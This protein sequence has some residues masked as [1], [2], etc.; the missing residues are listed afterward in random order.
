M[1]PPVEFISKTGAEKRNIEYGPFQKWL[2]P[3]WVKA[4]VHLDSSTEPKEVGSAFGFLII[5]DRIRTTFHESMEPPSDET[6]ELAFTLFD[7]YGELK[8]EIVDHAVRKGSG[9]W[10]DELNTGNFVLIEKVTVNKKWRRRGIGTKLVLLLL[11]KAIALRSNVNFAFAS[12][13]LVDDWHS[14]DSQGEMTKEETRALTRSRICAV[15]SLFR[16][17]HFRRV[18]ITEWFAL[19]KDEKHLSRQL[20]SHEDAGPV[21]DDSSDAD[22]D[23]KMLFTFSSELD[24]SN[25]KISH[26]VLS[27]SDLESDPQTYLKAH[28]TGK[29]PVR[30]KNMSDLA[31]I[32]GCTYPLHYAIRVLAD[33]DAVKFL[34]SHASKD[35]PGGLD[36][37]DGRGDTVLHIA[38]T[39]SKIGCL[40]WILDFTDSERL[41]GM[42]NREG[43]TAKE[44]LEARLE[45][46]RIS[47]PYGWQRR[48]YKADKFDGFDDNSV[49]CLLKFAGIDTPTTEQQQM[50]KFGCTCGQCLAGFLS[51]R[52]VIAL[53]TEAQ[54]TFDYISSLGLVENG[55]EWHQNFESLSKYLPPD[56]H[57]RF[58]NSKNKTLRKVFTTLIITVAKCLAQKAIPHRANV[59]KA[60]KK[61]SIWPQIDALYLKKGGTIASAVNIIID[62][63]KEHDPKAGTPLSDT[64]SDD[65]LTALPECRNDHEFEF[66]RR[67]CIDDAP[68]ET[69]EGTR[70]PYVPS[71]KSKALL[72]DYQGGFAM[73]STNASYGLRRRKL[74]GFYG[75][76]LNISIQIHYIKK[77]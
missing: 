49:A 12:M 9:V 68:P 42:R 74:H 48:K 30:N 4:I 7:R 28:L 36:S 31:T 1:T 60:V 11:G 33:E 17:L 69:S 51:P 3:I 57:R 35:L 39:M 37:A 5:R 75:V 27:E 58:R 59:I 53:C 41:T 71:Y 45:S 50:A 22:D 26:A 61:T 15:T 25:P 70:F 46:E 34:A 66:I 20:P 13:G 18:G 14:K 10:K 56:L 63:A 40:N 47:E 16:S 23:E 19:A 43:Y 52:M 6:M 55:G 73:A 54:T 44:A 77:S 32:L 24:G 38:A 64:E 62:G 72:R 2:I 67:H 8:K 65:N 76:T 29:P 21:L